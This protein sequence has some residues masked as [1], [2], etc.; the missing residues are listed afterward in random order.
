[1]SKKFVDKLKEEKKELLKEFYTLSSKKLDSEWCI[2]N[3]RLLELD[4]SIRYYELMVP[5]EYFGLVENEIGTKGL[6]V[7]NKNNY[8]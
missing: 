1:M 5:K 2:Y 6:Q 7:I 3:Q 4:A 8:E